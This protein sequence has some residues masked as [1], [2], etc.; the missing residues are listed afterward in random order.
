MPSFERSRTSGVSNLHPVRDG[1]RV[2]R[3]ILRERVTRTQPTAH[4]YDFGPGAA[5]WLS[6][7][8]TA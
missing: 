6:A 7:E 8:Q 5:P 2:L 4:V 1:L 3:V